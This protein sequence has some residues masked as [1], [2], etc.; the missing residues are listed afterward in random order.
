MRGHIRERSPGHW[1]IILDLRDP[2]TGKRRRKWHSFSGTKR[3]AQAQC[4]RLITEMKDGAYVETDKASLSDFLDRWERDWM[5]TNVSPKTA[6]RYSEL[7]RTHIRP[8]FGDKRMQAIRAE[9]LNKLYAD[10]HLKLAPRTIKHVH[11]LLHR[12]FGHAAKWGNVKRNVASL[13]DAPKAP[14]TE[15]PAL[16]L[17]EIPKMFEALRGRNLFPIAVVALGTGM[18]RGELCALRWQDVD[19]DGARLQVER[20]LEQTRKEGLR[21]KSPK[22]ARGRRT[23]SLSPAVVAQLRT[24]WKAQQE[25]RLSLGLGGASPDGLVFANWDGSARLPNGLTKEFAEAMERAGL[26]HVTLHTLRHTHASQLITSGM[27]IL[28]VSRRLGHSSAAITLT[29]YGHLLTPEDRAADIIEAMFATA[30]I[31]R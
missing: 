16:Q 27:D 18:R 15:A 21:F 30:E 31:N 17:A 10:L 6:E 28:T 24:H 11:R 1:A 3:E 26:A 25:Q 23:I 19:L 20:S 13:V 22:S 12:V 4:A 8:A 9:D 2:Q 29:V 7:L 14:A 5:A